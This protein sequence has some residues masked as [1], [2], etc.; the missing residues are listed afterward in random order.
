MLATLL[1]LPLTFI[2]GVL[3]DHL[4]KRVG[5]EHPGV[6]EMLEILGTTPAPGLRAMIYLSAILIA[7]LFEEL[8]F[9][10]HVQTLLVGAFARTLSPRPDDLVP[11]VEVPPRDTPLEAAAPSVL[12]YAPPPSHASPSAGAGARWLAIVV[13]SVLFALVHGAVW[14]MP[15]IFFFSLCL[16]YVYERTGNLWAAIAVHLLFNLVNVVL[17]VNAFGR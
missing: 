13:T 16:G 9:R 15:P 8:L 17:F 10:G 3:T 1:V 2:A 12:G 5:L 7:P 11:A 4:W 6:H 14:M